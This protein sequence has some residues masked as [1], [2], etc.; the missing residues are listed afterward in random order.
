MLLRRISPEHILPGGVP[1]C[2]IV[3]VTW[4]DGKEIIGETESSCTR[5]RGGA[6]VVPVDVFRQAGGASQSRSGEVR[7]ANSQNF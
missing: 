3:T 4:Q 2:G 5:R 1:N 7:N 6:C